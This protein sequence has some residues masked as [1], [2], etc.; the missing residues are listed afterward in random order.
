MLKTSEE[1]LKRTYL[2]LASRS[3]CKTQKQINARV[4]CMNC[5][6]ADKTLLKLENGKICTDCLKELKG[7]V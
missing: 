6:R 5:G 3:S 4:V 7:E 1:I 2:Y